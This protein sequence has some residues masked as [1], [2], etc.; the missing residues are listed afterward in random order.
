MGAAAGTA[1]TATVKATDA[2]G[3][4]DTNYLG[5][6][7]FSGKDSHNTALPAGQLPSDSPYTFVSGD[8]GIRSFSLTLTTAD[9]LTIKVDD[10]SLTASQSVAIT[11]L[12]ATHTS[13]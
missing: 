4:T 3:N 7:T 1:Q 6:V 13:H 12:A 10:T 8:H 2:Y 9:T 11:P 5:T